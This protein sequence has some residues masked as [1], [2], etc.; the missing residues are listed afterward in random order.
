MNKRYEEGREDFFSEPGEKMRKQYVWT[1][2]EKG[3]EVLQETAPIDIQQEIES[4]SD[5]CDIKNIVRKASFDPQFMKS[6]SQGAL[7]G[8]EVDITE[9]PQNIHEYHRMIA[10]A[11]AN[12]M[13]LEELQKM[14]AEQAKAETVA[15]PE[16]KP[17]AKPEAKSETKEKEK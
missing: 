7:D 6:L 2:D 4:Y 5:E 16:T 10:T 14:A 12:A 9:W 11:Q 17:E 13:K 3:Q 15:K 1:K 8:T